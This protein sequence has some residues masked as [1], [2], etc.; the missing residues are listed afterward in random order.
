M[1]DTGLLREPVEGALF[2]CQYFIKPGYNQNREVMFTI[3]KIYC[4]LEIYSVVNIYSALVSLQLTLSMR[5]HRLWLILLS[6]I[7]GDALRA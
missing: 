1:T 5:H 3:S 7:D 6:R 2:P 4:R